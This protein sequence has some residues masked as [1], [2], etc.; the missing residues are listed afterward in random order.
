METKTTNKKAIGIAAAVLVV[1]LVLAGGIYYF[2]RPEVQEGSKTVML[3]IS[4]DYKN[5]DDA[6]TMEIKTD[7]AFLLDALI[8]KGLL[9]EGDYSTGDM[10]YVYTIDGVTAQDA[11]REWWGFYQNGTLLNTGVAETP[12]ADGDSYE[13]IL[14]TY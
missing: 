13:I 2:T 7:A 3:T 6:K 12:I 14:S 10:V 4:A 11:N 8:E 1:L 9:R 5:P